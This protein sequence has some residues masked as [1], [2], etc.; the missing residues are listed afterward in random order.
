MSFK[1]PFIK[2]IEKRSKT[3]ESNNIPKHNTISISGNGRFAKK[4]GQPRITGHKEG[5]DV[6]Q[7]TVRT[8]TKFN[9]EVLN[10]TTFCTE[11]W[12]RPKKEVEF[13]MKLPEQFLQE[14]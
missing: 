8:R 10:L 14:Y 13:L 9:V 1:L 7:N 3:F 6:V 2:K 5:V 11:T 4:I 12:K